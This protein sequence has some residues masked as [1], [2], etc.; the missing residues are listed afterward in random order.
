M[1]K[2]DGTKVKSVI[3]EI[4]AGENWRTER[5]TCRGRSFLMGRLGEFKD[6]ATT[7]TLVEISN[8]HDPW[9][10]ENAG[11]LV[12]DM[13]GGKT[14]K[15]RREAGKKG[16]K[17]KERNFSPIEKI[18]DDIYGVRTLERLYDFCLY[19]FDKNKED[20]KGI[21][22]PGKEELVRLLAGIFSEKDSFMEMLSFCPGAVFEIMMILS[23]EGGRLSFSECRRRFD[24]V[25][26]R[27]GPVAYGST[28]EKRVLEPYLLFKTV[29]H[30]YSSGAD[31]SQ[32][33]AFTVPGKLR[34]LFRSR[35]PFPEGYEI[36]PVVSPEKT[37]YRLV[38]ADRSFEDAGLWASYVEQGNLKIIKSGAFQVSSLRGMKKNCGI[39]EFYPEGGKDLS[40]M[41]TRLIALVLYSSR[42]KNPDGTPCL[43][44]KMIDGFL[45]NPEFE[46]TELLFHLKGIKQLSANGCE[47][48]GSV[49]TSSMRKVLEELPEGKWVSSENI[50]RYATLR[51]MDF[52]VVKRF[53]ADEHLYYD[54]EPTG[55]HPYLSGPRRV[56]I[57]G[58]D[59]DRAVVAP[60]LKALLFLLS[61]FGVVDIAYDR[62]ANRSR[63]KGK[64]YL[65]IFDGLKYVRLTKIGAFL[66]G[67]T[68]R[69]KAERQ[70]TEARIVL[71][72]KRLIIS[73][74]GEDRMKRMFLES[75][76]E[77]ITA[78]TWKVTFRSFLS[79]CGS[80][81]DIEK[82][83]GF[84]KKKIARDLPA[85]WRE[86]FDK[87]DGRV[88][89][90]LSETGMYVFKVKENPELIAALAGDPVL[91]KQVLKAENYHILVPSANLAR[92]KSRLA[93]LG[94]FPGELI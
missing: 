74:S 21:A 59:F 3:A 50:F 85:V 84:F 12:L 65:S 1:Q 33:L 62:P 39:D 28:V 16:K 23:W 34:M 56:Y 13:G 29:S 7:L 77:K 93:E 45:L 32:T 25:I 55:E 31:D 38:H 19:R 90:L 87:V 36:T 63:R 76:G 52:A 26:F 49:V 17:R 86:F 44:K 46:L 83:I 8:M 20:K 9:L 35:L 69:C 88:S 71:D 48:Y 92:V 14:A 60:L 79:R 41:R 82:R 66:I 72:D 18:V 94:F 47:T 89:P 57:T 73:L 67:K 43:L 53:A 75:I 37:E 70:R 40:L 51:N 24:A 80:G 78:G 58:N 81:R 6:P 61:S 2:N 64:E 30:G 42:M 22:Y 5:L 91:A 4:C 10:S 68:D 15:G 11:R 27:E 54:E